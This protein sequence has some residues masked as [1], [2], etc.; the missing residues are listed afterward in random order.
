M[1]RI[2]KW[3]GIGAGALMLVV[4]AVFAYIAA[5]F[6]P[7]DYKSAIIEAVQDQTGR[8][9]QLRGDIGMSF[10]P[11]LGAKL[12][13]AS[14]SERGSDTE[15]ASVAD[16]VIAVKLMPL[17]SKEV[18]VDAIELRGLRARIEKNKSGK[19]N[20]DDLKGEQK[21]EEQPAAAAGVKVDIDHVEVSDSELTYVDRMTGAQYQISK[22]N[23]KTGR[24]ATGVT[25]PVDLS[26]TVAAP[27][28]NSQ[29]DVK[30][31]TRLTMGHERQLYKLA[32]LD[33]SGK[34]SFGKFSGLNASA[35]GGLEARLATNEYVATGL[36]VEVNGK[37][38]GADMKLKLDAPKLTLTRDKVEGRKIALDATLTEPKGK[39]VAKLAIPGVQ[40]TFTAFKAGPIDADVEMQ[41]DG[42][43]TN[44]KLAGVL[45]GN[46]KAKRF[47]IANLALSAKVSDPKL[48]KGSFDAQISG[49]ARADVPKQTA[50][51]V[52]SGKL[53][54]SSV[55]GRFGVS[56]FSPLAVTFDMNA[57][58]L[59]VDRLM[60]RERGAKQ[61]A[62][63]AP[64]GS[65]NGDD[66]IDLSALKGVNAAGN[67]KI[68]R[69]TV[70]NLKA[71]QVRLDVKVANARLDVSPLVAQ[72]YQGTLNGS[73]SAQ[74]A[75]NAVFTVKQTL[76]NI[77]VG[78][79]LRDAAQIDTLEGRGSVSADLTTRG[80]TMDALK[81][82]LNGSA[83][84]DLKDG[85]IK[86]IDIAGTI[87]TYRTKLDQL[88][89]QPVKQSNMSQ[90]TDFSELKATFN[91]RNGVARNDDL[92]IKSPL[93]RVGGAGDIDIGHDR[94]DYVL[95]ATVVATS[96]GQGGRDA[97]NLAG[98]TVPVKLTGALDKPDWSID[99][100]GMAVGLAKQALQ[101][102]L[103]KRAF[104]GMDKPAADP[105]K[106]DAPKP[107]TPQDLISDRLKS[108]LGR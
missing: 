78:P 93:L 105:G 33:F 6:D 45:S 64:K 80:A 106:K 61:A 48:P 14:L 69:L 1:P 17:L 39:L 65:K 97:A 82:A 88:R 3:I 46:L 98:V 99:F 25:T 95:K 74:A 73:L 50:G 30:L 34:G 7:N 5:T 87:R 15:F 19:F 71:S 81:K 38:S 28:E 55:S 60:G 85:S 10:F 20:F 53:D 24:I 29:L 67:L 12:G 108:I 57:D 4:G 94:L 23:L 2:V 107:A 90:K 51:L 91:I 70:M 92:S 66:K 72:L 16:A 37:H 32:D 83:A 100:A 44:A 103:L 62:G 31:K 56:D 21:K 58:Q 79:L 75:D 102:E 59:D 36:S 77:A 41:G 68:G 11:T 84:V 35:Q 43:T 76:S 47:E 13:Q 40:G 26:A 86:G 63:D 18:V 89:G 101:A 54:E 96:K 22:L 8:K 27:A 42:R 49:S 104:G 9:L 52:F